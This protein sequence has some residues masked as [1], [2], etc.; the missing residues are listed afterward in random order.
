MFPTGSVVCGPAEHG[1]REGAEPTSR[2]QRAKLTSG[3]AV[4]EGHYA[5]SVV[6]YDHTIGHEAAVRVGMT[7]AVPVHPGK[8]D[9]F[10]DLAGVQVGEEAVTGVH[11]THDTARG[12]VRP[13]LM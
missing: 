6:L 3:A 11:E 8:T 7:A 4:A 12:F 13:P 1:R 2:S 10:R 9:D 5:R